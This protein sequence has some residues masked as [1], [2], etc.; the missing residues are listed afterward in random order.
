M[1]VHHKFFNNNRNGNGSL[2]INRPEEEIKTTLA[3]QRAAN[4]LI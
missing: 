1:Y 2:D 4:Q 3:I